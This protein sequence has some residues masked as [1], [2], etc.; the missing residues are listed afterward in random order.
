MAVVT[1]VPI[2]LQA[3]MNNGAYNQAPDAQV[4]NQPKVSAADIAAGRD[5]WSIQASLYDRLSCAPFNG[6][7]RLLADQPTAAAELLAAQQLAAAAAAVNAT[8]AGFD[9]LAVRSGGR[10][11]AAAAA[12][13]A[14][15]MA[16]VSWD[17]EVTLGASFYPQGPLVAADVALAGNVMFDL[18][19]NLMPWMHVQVS[20]FSSLYLAGKSLYSTVTSNSQI[21]QRMSELCA[22]ITPLSP[23]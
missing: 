2:A 14:D 11:A 6:H 23:A 4:I 8:R 1:S 18:A 3:A 22:V 19:Q 7:Q 12:A 13:A 21:S 15:D 10:A 16:A 9:S 17:G 20:F 5:L